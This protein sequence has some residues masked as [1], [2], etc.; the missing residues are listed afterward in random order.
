MPHPAE[1]PGEEPTRA[2]VFPTVRAQLLQFAGADAPR[3]G[4]PGVSRT[5]RHELQELCAR[6]GS[7]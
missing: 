2:Y 1:T 7:P 6:A 4:D 3:A 5:R